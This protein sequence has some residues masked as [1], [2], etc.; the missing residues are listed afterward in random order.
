M[1]LNRESVFLDSLMVSIVFSFFFLVSYEKCLFQRFF[2]L[3]KNFV[4]QRRKKSQTKN[5]SFSPTL[6]QI[7]HIFHR[8][9]N[10]FQQYWHRFRLTVSIALAFAI[11]FRRHLMAHGT[12][13]HCNFSFCRLLFCKQRTRDEGHQNNHNLHKQESSFTRIS[14]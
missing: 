8:Q 14:V 12:M 9:T 6:I 1:P 13:K 7:L 3:V 5:N 11:N 2:L 4:A 10:R